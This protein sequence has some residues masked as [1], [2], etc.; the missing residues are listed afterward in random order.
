MFPKHHH[1]RRWYI[2]FVPILFSRRYWLNL[3]QHKVSPERHRI[4]EEWQDLSGI[5]RHGQ[6]PTIIHRI[7]LQIHK[8]SSVY[9]PN[10]LSL[11]IYMFVM[12]LILNIVFI[13]DSS[14]NEELKSNTPFSLA[15]SS[16]QYC[17]VQV[18]P[19]T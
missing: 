11:L 1:L 19:L 13:H 6:F 8:W 4:C 5:I 15:Y 16:W 7:P 9:N 10:I 12:Y 14:Y 17:G 2:T 18:S 3:T